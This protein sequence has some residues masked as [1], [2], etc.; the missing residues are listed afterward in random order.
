MLQAVFWLVTHPVR[1]LTVRLGAARGSTDGNMIV[2]VCY[3]PTHGKVV[4][5]MYRYKLFNLMCY[6]MCCCSLDKSSG[7]S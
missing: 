1:L 2:P 3:E 6:C 7:R 4:H 5:Q